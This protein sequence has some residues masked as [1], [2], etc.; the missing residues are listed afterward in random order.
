MKLSILVLEL[1]A[2]NTWN[3][4]DG[5][6][7]GCS[8]YCNQ[9]AQECQC[10]PCWSLQDDGKTCKPESN[11]ITTTCAPE[12]MTVEVAECVY[13]GGNADDV[14][15]VGFE[16]SD[17]CKA[18][19]DAGT[20]TISSALDGCGA[21]SAMGDNDD[22]QFNNKLKVLDRSSPH[23]ILMMTDV[24]IDVSCAFETSANVS[25]STDIEKTQSVGGATNTGSLGF[26]ANYYTT[27]DFSETVGS[28]YVVNLGDDVF[29]G[30]EPATP[31]SLYSY[32]VQECTVSDDAGNSFNI[33]EDSCPNVFISSADPTS[34]NNAGTSLWGFSYRSFKFAGVE[35]ESVTVTVSC[36][37]RIMENS[38][39]T[40][41]YADCG[42]P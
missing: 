6:N 17:D 13:K 2:A 35:D 24:D 20:Y 14:L 21:T 16:D 25:T 3:C 15:V 37:V 34:Y 9:K 19:Y 38:A 7:N 5:A 18:T 12:G 33:L 27:S 11:L 22:I 39:A 32:H 4:F 31:N 29:L 1:V 8:H 36:N 40:G 23:G 30:I 10:P 26:V 41:S 42:A 28:D